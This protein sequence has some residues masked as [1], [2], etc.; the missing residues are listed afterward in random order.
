MVSLKKKTVFFLQFGTLWYYKCLEQ[1]VDFQHPTQEKLVEVLTTPINGETEPPCHFCYFVGHNMK[2]CP[3]VPNE[4]RNT[5]V[6]NSTHISKDCTSN[7]KI[8]QV[9]PPFM[10]LDE[11]HNF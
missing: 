7:K 11:F 8:S 2:K 6:G 4:Y 5:G 10:E 1:L 3:F 9:R